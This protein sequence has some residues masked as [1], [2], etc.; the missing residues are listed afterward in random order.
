[1][2]DPPNNP[3]DLAVSARGLV[4]RY[5]DVVAVDGIDLSVRRGV[6]LGLL[7]PNG[8]GK[9]T[10]IEMLEGLLT[11]D[12]GDLSILGHSWHADGRRIRQRIGVQL[13]ETR[14]PEKV[15]VHEVLR[16][17]A[18][19]YQKPRDVGEVLDLVGLTEKAGA[20]C[21]QL[22]GG[23]RQRLALGC[24]L[25]GD[26]E[27]LFLDEPTTGLD[28][29]ARRRVWEIVEDLKRGG[30]T[31]LLTTHYMDEAE[32]LSDELLILDHGKIIAQGTPRT[33]IGSLHVDSI[34]RFALNGVEVDPAELVPLSGVASA[35]RL[36]DGALSL[37]ARQLHTTVPVLL[38]WVRARGYE[39]TDLHTHR[40]TL[41]DVFVALTGR[42]LRDE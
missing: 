28:P 7:G 5:G 41:E 17:F 31:V 36:D 27:L 26:P 25:V 11:P 9:T 8:A 6:C 20:R 42:N 13:Q 40:P 24:A 23:Q 29:Q 34:V 33:I 2:Q 22:S 4:K 16:L 21:G 1:M 32:R 14:L 3:T 35:R 12:A 38:E 15:K 37:S 39:L 30:R 18:S 19:F 10:T